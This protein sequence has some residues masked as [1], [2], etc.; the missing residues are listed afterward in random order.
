MDKNNWIIIKISNKISGLGRRFLAGFLALCLM[1]IS[2]PMPAYA[3]KENTADGEQYIAAEPADQTA[4]G[5]AAEI[6]AAGESSGS[7]Q[8]S[9]EKSEE[10]EPENADGTAGTEEE[11]IDE[12]AGSEA[13]GIEDSEILEPDEAE[14]PEDVTE[15]PEATE[16][17]KQ[18]AKKAE[19]PDGMIAF[20]REEATGLYAAEMESASG[21]RLRVA[22]KEGVFPGEAA[23]EA[24]EITNEAVLQSI[25]EMLD[26]AEE[27]QSSESIS[28]EIKVY[29]YTNGSWHVVQPDTEAGYPVVT[30]SG[31]RIM[32]A[33]SSKEQEVQVY[34]VA[35]SEEAIL[36]GEAAIAAEEMSIREGAGDG[37]SFEVPHFSTY[38]ILLS[39]A[40]IMPLSAD[41]GA[42]VSMTGTFSG[43]NSAAGFTVN[44]TNAYNITINIKP[45]ELT[46]PDLVI[47][48][49]KNIALTYYPNATNATISPYLR[50]GA[51]SVKTTKDGDENTVLTYEFIS[52]TTE[53]GFNITLCP[54]TYLKDSTQYSVGAALTSQAVQA[55]KESFAVTML[56]PSIKSGAAGLYYLT[57][58]VTLDGRDYYDRQLI[59]YVY[60]NYA[61]HYPYEAIEIVVPIPAGAVP[62]YDDSSQAFCELKENV[63]RSIT[64]SGTEYGTVSYYSQWKKYDTGVTY[65]YPVLVYQLNNKHPMAAGTSSTWTYYPANA[66][67]GGIYLRY[68]KEVIMAKMGTGTSCSFS[69]AGSADISAVI[70]GTA[71][72][73]R[74][75]SATVSGTTTFKQ[76]ALT[77]F[78]ILSSSYGTG[79][80]E[81]GADIL[82]LEDNNY[83]RSRIT[84]N[85]GEELT[86]VTV[87]YTFD[88]R[89]YANRVQAK[90]SASSGSNLPATASVRYKT[91]KKG[92]TILT[93]TLTVAGNELKLTDKEDAIVWM[94]VVYNKLGSSSTAYDILNVYLVNRGDVTASN[95]KVTGKIMSAKASE[96]VAGE[97]GIIGEQAVNTYNFALKKSYPISPSSSLSKTTLNK[98]DTFNYTFYSGNR[99]YKYYVDNPVYY[100]LM[101][102]E[103]IF[104]GYTQPS[105]YKEVSSYTLTTREIT[106]STEQSASLGSSG[107]VSYVPAGEYLLYTVAYQGK[108][109]ASSA[110]HVM[111]FTVG[112]KV[113]TSVYQPVVYL[114]ALYRATHEN[115]MFPYSTSYVGTDILDFDQDGNISETMAQPYSYNNVQLNAA[116][117]LSIQAFLTSEYDQG[118]E[119]AGRNYQYNTEGTYKYYIY[120]GLE[121]GSYVSDTETIL[122]MPRT[123]ESLSFSGASY[124]STWNGLLSAAPVLEGSF[125][126]GAAITYS[127]DG[128][129]SYSYDPAGAGNSYAKVT[130]VKIVSASGKKLQS[131]ESA[132]ITLPIT[133]GFESDTLSTAKKAYIGGKTLYRISA[134]SVK[135][136]AEIAPCILT[137]APVAVNG[138][139]FKDYNGN[140][141]Q[142]EN[143]KS[144]NQYYNISLYRGEYTSGTTGLT[145]LASGSSNYTTGAYSNTANVFLPGY[146][147]I[148]VQKTAAEFFPS[149]T[150][151]EVEDNYAYYTIQLSGGSM[152]WLLPMPAARKLTVTGFV[153]G[154][155]L[156]DGQDAVKLAVTTTPELKE[157]E[158]VSFTSS[159]PDIVRVGADGTLHYV[160]D[161]DVTITVSVPQTSIYTGILGAEPVSE[162]LQVKARKGSYKVTLYTGGGTLTDADYS[163]VKDGE[164]EGTYAA[165]T[166]LALPAAAAMVP[167]QENDKFTGWYEN[168][169]FTGTAA[170]G[171]AAA[172][173]GDK[174][175][176]AKWTPQ[177]TKYETAKNVWA[178]GTFQEAVSYVCQGGRIQLFTD[179]TL[180]SIVYLTKEVTLLTN[181]SNRVIHCGSNYFYIY[182]N[183]SLTI[184]DSRLTITG[185]HTAGVLI[186]QSGSA[187]VTQVILKAG[188]VTNTGTG[189]AVNSNRAGTVSI[190]GGSLT[191]YEY[192]VVSNGKVELAGAPALGGS[193]AGIYLKNESFSTGLLDITGELLNE[194]PYAVKTYSLTAGLTVSS[195]CDT[196][197]SDCFASADKG[198]QIGYSSNKTL[199]LQKEVTI[200]PADKQSKTYGGNDPVYQY[201]ASEKVTI[202][203]QLARKTGE[204]AGTYDYTLGSLSG[205]NGYCLILK[206]GKVFTI[207]PKTVKLPVVEAQDYDGTAKGH[208]LSDTNEYTIAI[209]ED[210][211]DSAVRSGTYTVTA[212]LKDT[213][214]YCWPDKTTEPKAIEWVITKTDTTAP[215]LAGIT[216]TV[217]PDT[218]VITVQ[219][220][221]TDDGCGL[222]Q[223]A[224][225]L[226]LSENQVSFTVTAA[227]DGWLVT[228]T[229]EALTDYILT[230]SDNDGNETDHTL[231][232]TC[233]VYTMEFAGGTEASGTAPAS[234][235]YWEYQQVS[236]PA[237]PFVRDDFLFA[238]WQCEGRLYQPADSFTMPGNDV[239]LTARWSLIN[240]S[241][242]IKGTIYY[243]NGRKVKGAEMSL[244]NNDGVI[245]SAVT[246]PDGSFSLLDIP[247]GAY[248][249]T[250]VIEDPVSGNQSM[251]IQVFVDSGQIIMDGRIQDVSEA[252]IIQP[253]VVKELEERILA[254]LPDQTGAEINEIIQGND[255][256]AQ[257]ALQQQ[258]EA[259]YDKIIDTVKDLE[260][261]SERKREQF[262]DETMQKLEALMIICGS[263]NIIVKSDSSN[264]KVM[265]YEQLLGLVV[266]ADDLE[267]RK[268]DGVDITVTVEIVQIAEATDNTV[269]QD[270]KGIGAGRIVSAFH[271]ITIIKKV[272][273]VETI[274]SNLPVGMELVFAIPERMRGGSGYVVLRE[275]MGQIDELPTQK[276]GNLLFTVSSLFSTYAIAYVPP[277]AGRKNSEHQS[278]A[279]ADADWQATNLAGVKPAASGKETERVLDE[280]PKTGHDKTAAG[281]EGPIVVMWVET[282]KRRRCAGKERIPEKEKN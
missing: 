136:T 197:Y 132:Q 124:T 76:Y 30:F 231:A 40:G 199:V 163:K 23:L 279:D 250:V 181:G 191:G 265:E 193:K 258:V 187:G 41:T 261:L 160:S 248:T 194:S 210:D 189:S 131:N 212:E 252:H 116:Q 3:A 269:I 177:E 24:Y 112:P 246:E 164:Y 74:S 48:I 63:K 134:S 228:F 33:L 214:N 215:A 5:A 106:V 27:D 2:C 262:F 93:G 99:Y 245:A 127:N 137:P 49:P 220:K 13:E 273:N 282:K 96:E 206:T 68:T 201:T 18:P 90:L 101:P 118:G 85:T 84:N 119:A 91:V 277:A 238:G 154:G 183:G 190:L 224:V 217:D 20:A 159:D 56:N 158:A 6:P 62:G 147:T 144:N 94:E 281:S 78:L 146:Y 97:S 241:A 157:G 87:E 122:A 239:T 240:N 46:S 69:A 140:G 92:D 142:E 107:G 263:I 50:N 9:A 36:T 26:P 34:H 192:A 86:A 28:F 31:H 205:G 16:D 15:Q 25:E 108:N 149:L 221:I 75:G 73:L 268:Q 125:L 8:E 148:R 98:G 83:Y 235:T 65:D 162:A 204:T 226:M 255:S 143:E 174:I 172:A 17:A 211:K 77:D 254:I 80:V 176:Y 270:M 79:S 4:E 243:E 57:G 202:S 229:R 260:G 266:T 168:R 12:P 209:G 234:G 58:D 89:L 185:K 82:N 179:V 51:A 105:A 21:I 232:L 37:V 152:D 242:D 257:E 139:V 19:L 165:G 38:T 123:G 186:G 121:S 264:I 156:Y 103:Y 195:S 171:I 129:S 259:V 11:N 47:T 113:N 227:D 141:T 182:N 237:S 230:V 166:Y 39:E 272:G 247:N 155:Y 29:G 153:S 102:K 61:P 222:D 130:H 276:D 104:N 219:A 100:I 173:Y 128:G 52:E 117:A 64:V 188:T 55:A 213:S 126:T 203:G 180:S 60:L 109:L 10:A 271:E 167:E 178:Y 133:A 138:I 115:T 249:I 196:D 175:F 223:D 251:D 111:S 7:E 35:D 244:W 198:Y 71:V 207:E 216:E 200:T 267:R 42:E 169:E 22:F 53:I 88:S 66:N 278:G 280:V 161:G 120:N 274:I 151:W 45:A 72:K 184:D 67:M 1:V 170:A 253:N 59:S 110:A 208:G 81:T 145:L 32:E 233:D 275:H 218:G 70:D 150:G 95:V 236:L 225:C 135:T 256:A 43:S 114:P 54:N 14:V 44:G